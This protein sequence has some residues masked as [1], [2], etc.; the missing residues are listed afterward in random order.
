M[1]F[2]I[3]S[4]GSVT[5]KDTNST[6]EGGISLPWADNTVGSYLYYD[7]TVGVMLDSGIAVHNRLPQVNKIPD[8]LGSILYDDPN[9]DKETEKGVN[10][11][12]LDQ[13]QDI[14]QRMGHSRYWFRLW[15]EA[16]RIG[17][18]VPI[19]S[20][21]SV[22]GVD[23]VPYDKNPQWGYNKLAPNS[24]FGGVFLWVATWS[25]WYTT[26]VPPTSN[27]IPVA[28]PSALVTSKDFP[29]GNPVLPQGIQIPFSQPDD[30]ARQ[31]ATLPSNLGNIIGQQ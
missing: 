7:C 8:S 18:K 14:V 31:S 22:G 24:N 16:I 6:L 30:N 3:T 15:G 9:M 19:P 1:P 13:Y 5:N 10:L 20:L 25:L 29:N 26:V 4:I 27:N 23:V 12:S 11:R 17:Y 2:Q 21:K 28:N